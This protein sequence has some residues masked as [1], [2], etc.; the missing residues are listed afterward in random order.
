MLVGSEAR[1]RNS[2]VNVDVNPFNVKPG[3]RAPKGATPK[4]ATIEST[5]G[6]KP[7]PGAT[8]AELAKALTSLENNEKRLRHLEVTKAAY[9]FSTAQIKVR[10]TLRVAKRWVDKARF[11]DPFYLSTA[12]L[13]AGS[14]RRHDFHQDEAGYG[15]NAG[16]KDHRP[17]EQH[18]PARRVQH[19]Q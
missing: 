7:I 10:G 19:E 8:L 16:S 13:V 3:D 4:R 15:R 12:S 17:E 6:T 2:S 1:R 9:T 14:H 11:S 18:D 5:K